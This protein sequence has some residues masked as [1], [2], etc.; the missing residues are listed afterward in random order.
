[1]KKIIRLLYRNP[2]ADLSSHKD[3]HVQQALTALT[4]RL[5]SELTQSYQWF[6]F[7]YKAVN[8][9]IWGGERRRRRRLKLL[10]MTNTCRVRLSMKPVVKSSDDWARQNL[11]YGW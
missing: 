2:E 9:G 5:D 10:T 8:A 7:A 3:E 1:M 6:A 4:D 11:H